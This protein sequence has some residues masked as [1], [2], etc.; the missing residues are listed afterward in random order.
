M[1]K[2]REVI[3]SRTKKVFMR[4]QKEKKN[5]ALKVVKVL[6]SNHE[7]KFQNRGEIKKS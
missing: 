6:R 3:G 7:I 1:K 2:A 5:V 4:P